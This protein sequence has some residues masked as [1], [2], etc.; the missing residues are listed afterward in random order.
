MESIF[1]DLPL[2][3]TI[4][5]PAGTR[6][7]FTSSFIHQSPGAAE[8]QLQEVDIL[9]NEGDQQKQFSPPN[10]MIPM[11]PAPDIQQNSNKM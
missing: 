9:E 10:A 7:H 6:K 2:Q 5:R 1:N 11:T 3:T 4:M 8:K